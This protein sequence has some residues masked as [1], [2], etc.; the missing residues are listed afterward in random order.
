MTPTVSSIFF[1]ISTVFEGGPPA[2]P[3][4]GTYGS[5]EDLLKKK[6]Y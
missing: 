3:S 1:W 6:D 5:Y 4:L 2:A